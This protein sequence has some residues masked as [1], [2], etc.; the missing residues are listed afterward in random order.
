MLEVPG[1][2]ERGRGLAVGLEEAKFLEKKP[3]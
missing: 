2:R 3:G 1:E